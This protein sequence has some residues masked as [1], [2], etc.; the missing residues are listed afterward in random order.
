MTTIP[1][2][3]NA[4]Q[5]SNFNVVGR[6]EYPLVTEENDNCATRMFRSG[7]INQ[8]LCDINL[9]HKK[10]N[11]SWIVKESPNKLI[12]FVATPTKIKFNCNNDI[13]GYDDIIISSSI[14]ATTNC[15]VEI[16]NSTY[17]LTSSQEENVS[18]PPT[19][20]FIN[21]EAFKIGEINLMRLPVIT[22]GKN[23]DWAELGK[24]LEDL[25]EKHLKITSDEL[26]VKQKI[27]MWTAIGS[28]LTSLCGMALIVACLYCCLKI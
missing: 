10:I 18:I 9:F 12:V 7:H 17:A 27:T 28:T 25:N 23:S 24:H 3:R 22:S 21:V 14:E 19:V 13:T 6:L 11:G 1:S 16:D 20:D 8:I 2:L 5:L 26:F 15:F 4:F